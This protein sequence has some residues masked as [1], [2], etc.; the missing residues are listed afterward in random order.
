MLYLPL[1]NILSSSDSLYRSQEQVTP[2]SSWIQDPLLPHPP[3][4]SLQVMTVLK[5]TKLTI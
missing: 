4:S 1:A 3:L 5:T 2:S